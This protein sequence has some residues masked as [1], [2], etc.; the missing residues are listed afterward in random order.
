M[1]EG[2][3]QTVKTE[4]YE[5]ARIDV[6]AVQ[7]GKPPSA[8]KSMPR[9]RSDWPPEKKEIEDKEHQ[10][11]DQAFLDDLNN[12]IEMIHNIG[13]RFSIHKPT[14]RTVVRVINKDNDETIREIPPEKILDLAAKIDEMMGIMFDKTV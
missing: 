8:S 10:Q 3:S 1:I 2:V 14:G 5:A 4:N 13:L 12:D 7:T 6:R 9:Q 11:I